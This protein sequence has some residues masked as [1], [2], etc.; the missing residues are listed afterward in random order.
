[1][2]H[3]PVANSRRHNANLK[4]VEVRLGPPVISTITAE[5]RGQAD[6]TYA[7]WIAAAKT[8]RALLER[9]AE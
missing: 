4:I 3:Q 6:H 2:P 5:V 9:E 8:V 1:M 7:D